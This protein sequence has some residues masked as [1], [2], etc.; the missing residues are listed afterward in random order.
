MYGDD[1]RQT[2]KHP[3]IAYGIGGVLLVLFFFFGPW[4]PSVISDKEAGVVTTLGDIKDQ[5]TGTGVYWRS[6]FITR[7][8]RIDMRERTHTINTETVSKEG[9]KF[10]VVIT[11]RYQVK[12]GSAIELVKR[13]QTPL[14]DLVMTYANATIDDVATGK[15]KDSMYSDEGRVDIVKAVREILNNELGDYAQI[16]QVIFEDIR[17]PASITEAIEAQQAELEKIKRTE[18]QKAVAENQA[19]IRRIE[20]Q[21]IADSNQ[22]IQSSLTREY[23]QYEAIQK[24]NPSAEKVYIPQVGLVPTITY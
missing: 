24:F 7:L 20:A 19:E 15:D 17:L 12:D 4:F 3:W 2:K 8:D 22:I 23:L 10:G 11:V 9:L 6:P 5:T 18:N 1:R 21:G 14:N 13:L 16:N